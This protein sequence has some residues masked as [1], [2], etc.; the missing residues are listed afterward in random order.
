MLLFFC[1]W[2]IN[3]LT[4]VVGLL[5]RLRCACSTW[6]KYGNN[7]AITAMTFQVSH[8][9]IPSLQSSFPALTRYLVTTVN[10]IIWGSIEP[11]MSVIAACLPILGPIIFRNRR[12]A[13][14]KVAKFSGL[15]SYF[16]KIGSKDTK[17]PVL[18]SYSRAL[19]S[20]DKL[21]TQGDDFSMVSMAPRNS[22][23]ETA[24]SG[25]HVQQDYAV[26]EVREAV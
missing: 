11:C 12:Q 5:L 21:N 15:S 19:G 13:K 7:S 20:I 26:K 10:T 25:I 6:S 17:G 2:E 9:N 3:E 18:G 23:N 1:C 4:E 24:K 8:H 22:E 14:V 16:R